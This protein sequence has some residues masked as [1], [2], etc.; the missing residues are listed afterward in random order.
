MQFL[1]NVLAITGC[2]IYAGVLF[3]IGS[4]LEGYWRSKKPADFLDWFGECGEGLAPACPLV[5]IQPFIGAIGS[6]I[7]GW[8]VSET[9]WLWFAVIACIGGSHALAIARFVPRDARSAARLMP[10]HQTPVRISTWCTL[11]R[12]R[13]TLA[14][15]ASQLGIMAIS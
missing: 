10:P 5:L 2:A 12:V 1:F 4:T 8:N 14:M 7:L 3:T 9:R 15:L 13:V 6:L 11:H